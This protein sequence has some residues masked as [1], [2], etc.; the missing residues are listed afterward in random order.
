MRATDLLDG[1]LVHEGRVVVVLLQALDEAAENLLEGLREGARLEHGVL[2][3]AHLCA[4]KDVQ[5][6][7]SPCRSL[8][9]WVPSNQHQHRRRT[10]A[11]ATSF[12]AEVIFL[13]FLTEPTRSRSSLTE[14]LPSVILD[15]PLLPADPLF[16]TIRTPCPHHAETTI[17]CVIFCAPAYRMRPL[18]HVCMYEPTHRPL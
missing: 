13:V 6:H 9:R 2:S 15:Q 7:T 12:M 1:A 10:L 18:S 5:N 8:S 14:P 4:N 3:T 11:A 17:L 16:L